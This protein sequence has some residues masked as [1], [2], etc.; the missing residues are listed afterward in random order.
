M[1]SDKERPR[2]AE[3]WLL[4]KYAIYSCVSNTNIHNVSMS[5][6]K[7]IL[8]SECTIIYVSFSIVRLLNKENDYYSITNH[9]A[10]MI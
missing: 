3:L 8:H 4:A 10:T 7:V 2:H 9:C 1:Y 6:V 5:T